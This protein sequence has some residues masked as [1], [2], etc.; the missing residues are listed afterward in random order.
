MS[1]LG[2]FSQR[3]K[4]KCSPNASCCPVPACFSAS[5]DVAGVFSWLDSGEPVRTARIRVLGGRQ[6]PVSV[7]WPPF[8]PTCGRPPSATS[9]FLKAK[10]SAALPLWRLA[11][12]QWCGASR[13]YAWASLRR[14]RWSQLLMLQAG[15]WVLWSPGGGECWLCLRL[16]RHSRAA[17]QVLGL[18]GPGVGLW[19][20]TS[21]AG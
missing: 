7:T 13:V 18:P 2:V 15:D 20:R 9:R 6:L 14:T 1:T 8:L 4:Q 21:S 3:G 16:G 19:A 10:L 11:M 17:S 12:P 5:G